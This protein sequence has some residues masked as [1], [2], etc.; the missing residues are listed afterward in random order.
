MTQV[1]PNGPPP[2]GPDG[3]ETAPESE[4]PTETAAS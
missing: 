3:T 2:Q 4:T 1:H